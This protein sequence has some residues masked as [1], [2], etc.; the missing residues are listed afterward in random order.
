MYDFSSSI[1]K[2]TRTIGQRLTRDVLWF[3]FITILLFHYH[4]YWN[5]TKKKNK[6][7]VRT[8]TLQ[9]CRRR[10]DMRTIILG[11]QRLYEHAI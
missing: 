11:V 8:V 2:H 1:K 7:C 3:C 10:P 9:C 6:K 4:Y 5:T